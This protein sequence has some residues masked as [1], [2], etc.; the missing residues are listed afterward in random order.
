MVF[1]LTGARAARPIAGRTLTGSGSRPRAA[2][3]RKE[4]RATLSTL[5]ESLE[6]RTYLTAS[7]IVSGFSESDVVSLTWQGR[8]VE[9]I[10]DSWVV[11]M[12]Q[13]NAATARNVAD[14]RSTRPHVP[15]GWTVRDLGLGFFN[16]SAPGQSAAAVGTWAS[17]VGAGLQQ[18]NLVHRKLA[19]I[20]NEGAVNPPTNPGFGSLWG[21][22]NT[23]QVGALD[24]SPTTNVTGAGTPG[25]DIDVT[26]VWAGGVT[27]SRDI[28]IA[29]MDDGIDYTHT[30]LQANMWSRPANVPASR[31]GLHG[32]DSADDDAD[33]RSA[34]LTDA[35]GTH[36]AGTIGAVG[37]N[38]E[39]ISGI[40]QEV[41]L[42]GAKVF[43][44]GSPGAD[45][46][47]IIDAINRVVE[48]RAT[49]G[50]NIVAI[51]ASLGGVRPENLAETSA[52]AAAG[53]AG[54]LFVAAAGNGGSDRIGDNNDVTPVF[55]A[56]T[57]LPNVISV[58]ASN[59]RDELTVFSNWGQ[60]VH[61]AAP[62]SGI[63]STVP[64][65]AYDQYQGTSMAAPHVAGVAGLIA[66]AYYAQT[67]ELP[68]VEIMRSAILDGADVIPTTAGV[69]GLT[70]TTTS[71]VVAGNRRLNA[72][73]AMQQLPVIVSVSDTEVT[74]GDVGQATVQV[75]VSLSRA[76][77]QPVTV[78][79]TTRDGTAL[80]ADG[81][82]VPATGSLTF[83]AGQTS[84]TISL[85]VNGDEW[86][87]RDEYFE[88]V[89]STV[90]GA[91]AQSVPGRFT[92]ANDDP[93]VMRID[94]LPALAMKRTGPTV[95]D[96]ILRPYM[97]VR[98]PL[99]ISYTTVDGT[100][101]A[102]RDYRPHNGF[103]ELRPGQTEKRLEVSILGNRRQ[104]RDKTFALAFQIHSGP[105]ALLY[106]PTD[107]S[108]DPERLV[109]PGLIVDTNSRLFSLI[110][111][112]R[113]DNGRFGFTIQVD[114]P[115]QFGDAVPVIPGLDSL[116]A[117][118][119]EEVARR[120]R[121]TT[122]YLIGHQS[123][124]RILRKPPAHSDAGFSSGVVE[125]GYFLDEDT[126]KLVMRTSKRIEVPVQ[127]DENAR[128]TAVELVSPTNAQIKPGEGKVTLR[129]FA[130]G[131]TP[132]DDATP[133]RRIR[134]GVWRLFH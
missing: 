68:T 54:I 83:G 113:A 79:Y 76:L 80:A 133:L 73:G 66:S 131:V 108:R 123:V 4:R 17:Q 56:N 22:Q 10:R 71:G 27:G 3:G 45:S 97:P 42:Y 89:I 85:V 37:D 46:A 70:N 26:S 119:L 134:P 105:D 63:W 44:D 77:S 124:G 86:F 53:S 38:G 101:K 130:L 28:I 74:E 50:Q 72:Y 58:A 92:I 33:I 96:F 20:P 104:E 100:A 16:I 112:A 64:G 109:V 12:P 107:G 78:A 126:G 94:V 84:G 110:P 29:V 57:P 19:E 103:I 90:S 95:A 106:N 111:D 32:W 39:G 15:S 65:D 55:P 91:T 93:E 11:R 116:P 75:T 52:I 13:I 115:R 120:T 87:E 88:V 8:Q 34:N 117:E 24:S 67:G 18:P 121:F 5:I 98:E 49:Y 114:R 102:G 25:S 127:A 60:G 118:V 6:R 35:H 69:S 129:S 23:G 81:D 41:Q 128:P 48:L 82:Y 125:L 31:Y 7:P 51:N 99:R 59:R 62:G 9:A 61:I 43:G 30:D 40:M 122:H 2:G 1:N 36:V 132:A 47:D 21:L 14:Y